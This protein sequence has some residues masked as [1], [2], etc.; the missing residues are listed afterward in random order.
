MS[1]RT[2]GR[3]APARP[4]TSRAKPG[5]GR[6][7]RRPARVPLLVRGV[8]L[9]LAAAV[10]MWVWRDAWRWVV[11]AFGVLTVAAVFDVTRAPRD[12]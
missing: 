1:S 8:L 6:S 9:L 12:S 11:L 2:K 5:A 10:S 4:A 7:P 3:P